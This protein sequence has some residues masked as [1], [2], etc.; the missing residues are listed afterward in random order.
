M[1][2][3][4]R[5]SPEWVNGLPASLLA[6]EGKT[7][8]VIVLLQKAGLNRDRRKTLEGRRRQQLPK[9]EW[10]ARLSRT[11]QV[12]L[13]FFMSGRFRFNTFWAIAGDPTASIGNVRYAHAVEVQLLDAYDRQWFKHTL[14]EIKL[15]HT[16]PVW[17]EVRDGVA[18]AARLRTPLSLGVFMLWPHLLS[19]LHDFDQLD[20]ARRIRVA[21]AVFALSTVGRT[22]WFINE[23]L[24]L[25]PEIADEIGLAARRVDT[26]LEGNATAED[27][28]DADAADSASAVPDELPSSGSEWDALVN[29]LAEITH[30]LREHPSREAVE[31]LVVLSSRFETFSASLPARPGPLSSALAIRVQELMTFLQSLVVREAFAWLDRD[32]IFQIEARWG[33]ALAASDDASLVERLKQDAHEALARTSGAAAAYLQAAEDVE[34]RLREGAE[35]EVELASAKGFAEQAAIRRRFAEAKKHHLDAEANQLARQ[36]HLIDAASPFG[37]VFDYGADYVATLSGGPTPELPAQRT[38]D[39]V[40]ES[41]GDQDA[42]RVGTIDDSVAAASGVTASVADED[43]DPLLGAMSDPVGGPPS[44]DD[45]QEGTMAVTPDEANDECAAAP[46]WDALAIGERGLAYQASGWMQETDPSV[47]VP[48]ADL[49]AATAFA[50]ELMLPDGALHTALVSRFESLDANEFSAGADAS[51]HAATNLLL[52]TAT[53]RPMVLAPSSGAA[54]VA[55]YLHHDGHYPALYALVQKLRELSSKLV[56][57]RIEPTVL[58][59]AR[60]EATTKSDLEELKVRATDWLTT[61]APAYTIRFA[62]ATAVWKQWLRPGGEIESLVSPVAH[63]KIQDAQRIREALAQMADPAHIQRL[64][65]DTD[66]KDLRRRRGDDI[67][68][69]ALDHLVRLVEEGL[70][71]PRKWLS[72]VELIGTGGNRLRSLLGD[73][74]AALRDGRNAVEEELTRIPEVDVCGMV[75][76]SQREVLRSLHDMMALFDSTSSLPETE[77]SPNEV[78]G[79]AGLLVPELSV[80]ENW[81]IETAPAR[82]LEALSDIDAARDAEVA[83]RA[84]IARG[85]L[86]GAEMMV[87]TGLVAADAALLRPE[88]ERW[89]QVLRREIGE[90]RRAVEIGSAYGYVQE[91]DRSEIETQLARHE[92]QIDDERRFDVVLDRVRQM[93]T[94]VENR[95]EERKRDVRAALSEIV[96]NDASRPAALEVEKA[97]DA[98]DIA[99]ANELVDWLQQGHPRSED[100]DDEAREGFSE[101]FPS[102]MLAINAWLEK[103]S[104][105]PVEVI[106]QGSGIPGMEGR[107]IDGAQRDQA[108]AM[109]SAWAAMKQYREAEATRLGV[110][111]RGL[112]MTVKTLKSAET[113][114]GREVWT[115]DVEPLEDRHI[116]VLPMF[117]SAAAGR[118]RV[119]CVWGR[120]TEDELLQWV[121]DATAGRP[122]ILLYFGRMTERKWRDLGRMAKAKRRSFLFLDETL[123]VYLCGAAGGRLRAWFDAALPF[124]YSSPYDATAGLVPPEMFYGRG[125]ELDAVLGTNGRCFIYGG[126]QLGKTALLKRAEQSFHSP[127]AGRFARWIDL[128]A[129]GIGVS[130]AASD[131]WGILH[132]RF[133]ELQIIDSKSAERAPTRKAA[134][135]VIRAIREFLAQDADRRILLL[136]DEA[137]RFFEHDGRNDFEET[138][139]LKQ[140]MDDTQ[141]HFKVVFA[142]LHNVLRMTER[143][144]HPLAHFGEPIEIGPLREGPE[145]REAAKLIRRPM[146]AAGFQFESS[147]LVIRI[148]AQTNYYPSLIQLYCSHLLRHMLS[149]V[150]GSRNNRTGPRYVVTDRDIEQVYSS[151]ALRD[152]IRAKFR[153]TL[154]LDP[155]YEVLAYSMGLALLRG[156]YSQTEGMPWQTI[157]QAGALHWW[158]EGFHDTAEADF[159]VLL[160]EMVLLGVLRRPSEGRYVL[161]N[162]N[163]LLLLGTREE[164][165]TVLAKEREPAVEFESASFRP[166][167]GVAPHRPARNVFTYQQ[168]SGLLQRKNSI[169]VVTG[170]PAAGIDSVLSNLQDYQAILGAGSPVVLDGATDRAA[171]ASQLQ[172]W[173]SE[174]TNDQVSVF[175]VPDSIPWTDLWLKDAH[176]LL[177]T[178]RSESKFASL[179]FVAEPATLWRLL[180]DTRA[181]PG[182]EV[183]WMSLLHWSDGFLRHWLDECQLHLEREERRLLVEATGLWPALISA[184]AGDRPGLRV[185]RDRIAAAVNWP[186]GKDE[187]ERW[188]ERFG[189]DV[190]EPAKVLDLLARWGE[191]ATADDLAVVGEF[192]AGQVGLYLRWAEL[193]GL[194]R[195]EGAGYW[196]VDPVTAKVFLGAD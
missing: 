93:R 155:R 172:K 35:L 195:R 165:E 29:R 105:D 69:G 107:R 72:L 73:V 146:E 71:L 159:K 184:H 181:D 160:E 59:L 4:E 42:P 51:W 32:L 39:P 96:L 5:F 97:L 139:R 98:G 141:R 114:S 194:A 70:A 122:A 43:T 50:A 60:S 125:A 48:S 152:E 182:S 45:A 143:P 176:A 66:R 19:D 167:L 92:A 162:P 142:G 186:A 55:A 83:Q 171:F 47:R 94:R 23:A 148:L 188:C 109:F 65:T 17:P 106:R 15:V 63:N 44:A 166:P 20:D 28:D 196:M 132:E 126:R 150:T 13:S 151:D 81:I 130:V 99:T 117:G 1:H 168:L 191:P 77:R 149:E 127:K 25:R 183:P 108:A 62:P 75:T 79:R 156:D 14:D 84:R 187:S 30:E 133:R 67:H 175:V 131:I 16:C 27:V 154:Q 88:R 56:G 138:R 33:L 135:K 6:P 128:R 54:T 190:A 40:E 8:A 113:V 124:T 180:R 53:L 57:F 178:L 145:V 52:A 9:P 38:D 90:C 34:S 102:S 74:H 85:D 68:A 137:D 116:C 177:R 121:G 153:L 136:L 3:P 161:R 129:E 123:L 89:R 22:R 80:A 179:V 2:S 21:H 11:D 192:D 111:L 119:I 189:L 140:L 193:L 163:V 64:I 100:L 36:E 86:L 49:L 12:V 24:A 18:S 115:L 104:R 164:I 76:S 26:S 157:R 147:H 170:T 82:A 103:P 10:M 87:E 78:L 120:P 95:R 31:E 169:T 144:N 41:E 91:A 112:G 101:F 46:I 158:V 58:R 134:E 118:Y 185:L 110:L 61:Q 7:V 174:R 37:E 173:L